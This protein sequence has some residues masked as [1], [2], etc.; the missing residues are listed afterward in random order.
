MKRLIC[1]LLIVTATIALFPRRY[2]YYHSENKNF[3]NDV[4][5]I[6]RC[7]LEYD[8]VIDAYY[9]YYPGDD[10]V[11]Y[12]PVSGEYITW[13]GE[14]FRAE[15]SDYGLAT[16]VEDTK[17]SRIAFTIKIYNKNNEL[18]MEKQNFCSYV[19]TD[20]KARDMTYVSVDFR[21]YWRAMSVRS[22]K[23]KE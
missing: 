21:D 14:K 10:T 19:Q 8:K 15:V 4:N 1:V 3:Y 20:K 7:Y 9:K 11:I 6:F 5:K 12:F 13:K 18:I 16:F 23:Y 17:H 2:E 22:D